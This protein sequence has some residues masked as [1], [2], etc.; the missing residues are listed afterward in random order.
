MKITKYQCDNC[1]VE[2]TGPFV[3]ENNKDYCSFCYDNLILSTIKVANKA[4]ANKLPG[5]NRCKETGILKKEE[6]GIVM[7]LGYYDD[8][9]LLGSAAVYCT[10]A[11]GTALN[12]NTRFEVK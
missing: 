5:C 4:K 11:K 3:T 12:P 1:T 10:C 9:C 6:V 7:S 2:I 8:P